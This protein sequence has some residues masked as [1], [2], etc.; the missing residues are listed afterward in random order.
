MLKQKKW[1]RWGIYF[2]ITSLLCA[3]QLS[4]K[5]PK[6][7]IPPHQTGQPTFQQDETFSLAVWNIEWFPALS[8]KDD[9]SK[10]T[11]IRIQKISNFIKEKNPTILFAC[12][13][14]DIKSLKLLRLDYPFLACADFT[15]SP[16]DENHHSNQGLA[17]LSKIAWK[18]IWAIDLTSLPRTDDR[19]PRGI[20]GAEFIL[21]SGKNLTLYGVHLKS[22][23]A[24]IEKDILQRER[25]MDYLEADWKRRNLDPQRDRIVVVGDFNTSIHDP[26]FSKETTIRRLLDKGFVSAMKGAS[27]ETRITLKPSRENYY[28]GADFDHIFFSRPLW[29]ELHSRGPWG[30]IFRV[31]GDLSDHYFLWMTTLPW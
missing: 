25:A 29:K 11:L 3:F 16:S 21:P 12:E 2:L 9:F 28:H 23:R 18:E 27:K 10:K 22:N 8:S 24:M 4:Q 7:V 5:D 6:I 15:K 26:A 13:I 1:L 17:L 31:K 19:P 20:L 14:R 30:Q